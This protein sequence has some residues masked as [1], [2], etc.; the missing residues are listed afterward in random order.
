MERRNDDLLCSHSGDGQSWIEDKALGSLFPGKVSVGVSASNTSKK[1]F[2]ARFESS[3]WPSP[4]R[5]STASLVDRTLSRW[6]KT[7]PTHQESE[8]DRES[9]C[10]EIS[11][12][13]SPVHAIAAS[14]ASRRESSAD[15]GRDCCW[16]SPWRRG[17]RRRSRPPN[18]PCLL[19][20]RGD[21]PGADGGSWNG[22]GAG[23]RDWTRS[24]SGPPRRPR[25]I[26]WS[27]P[28]SATGRASS[29][30]GARRGSSA[31]SPPR[32]RPVGWRRS[33]TRGRR[34]SS[35]SSGPGTMGSS[36]P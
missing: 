13:R 34:P 22:D 1:A 17:A 16:E 35:S 11:G 15:P 6:G 12:R 2:P 4:G 25:A 19:P 21:R 3:P 18:C 32:R 8:T 27:W 5:D 26:P 24:R 20:R 36:R 10:D 9:P 14:S 7:G 28:M 31:R 33:G 23:S 30:S 29:G